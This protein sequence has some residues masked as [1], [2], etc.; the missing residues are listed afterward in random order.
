MCRNKAARFCVAFPRRGGNYNNT[1]NAGLGYENCNNNR[2]NTNTNYG[3]RP[4]SPAIQ[5]Y[6]G[7]EP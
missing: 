3:G 1:S 5:R 2:G 6:C 4:R 7:N